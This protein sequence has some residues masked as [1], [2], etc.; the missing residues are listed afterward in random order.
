MKLK[1]FTLL[2]MS[3]VL[4]VIVIV[5]SVGVSVAYPVLERSI[6]SQYIKNVEAAVKSIIGDKSIRDYDGSL[7]SNGYFN[8]MGSFPGAIEDLWTAP[9]DSN[10]HYRKEVF[11]INGIDGYLYGGWNGPYY[12]SIND[13][14]QNNL[15]LDRGD[16]DSASSTD[17][18]VDNDD[19][20][21]YATGYADSEIIEYGEQFFKPRTITLSGI[22]NEFTAKVTYLFFDEGLLQTGEQD[23]SNSEDIEIELPVGIC[24]FHALLE[25]DYEVLGV[26]SDPPT[27]PNTDDK[28]LVAE[29]ATSGAF[30]GNENN[31][32]TW[33]GTSYDYTTPTDLETLHDTSE[34]KFYL[35][36]SSTWQEKEVQGRET[37]RIIKTMKTDILLELE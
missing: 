32:A 34:N 25:T 26:L 11:T 10:I 36:E 1:Y 29:S 4:L 7:I 33:N 21:L 35:Y 2:E 18:N 5:A 30:V 6:E 16:Y 28:F 37:P 27:S 20:K 24:A 9:S 15:Q 31:I 14:L 13:N 3:V 12:E 17:L 19:V 23:I 22:P 8:D